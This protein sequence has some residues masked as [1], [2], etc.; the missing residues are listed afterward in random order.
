MKPSKR[1]LRKCSKIES[2]YGHVLLYNKYLEYGGSSKLGRSELLNHISASVNDLVILSAK[3]YAKIVL[4][5]DN[6]SATL[7]MTKSID[8]D[9]EEEEL[10]MA[11][12]KVAKAV[13]KDLSHLQYNSDAYKIHIS[14]SVAKESV[15]DSLLKLLT[16]ISPKLN[17]DALQ[18][19]CSSKTTRKF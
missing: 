1:S 7:K 4:F 19:V 2:K 3:G 13:N 14:K 18:M 17:E 11:P 12:Q 16:K 6:A 5:Q 8:D 9:D 15:S 10:D